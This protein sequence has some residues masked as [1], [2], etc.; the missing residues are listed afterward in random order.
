MLKLFS[1]FVDLKHLN[2][3]GGWAK[4]TRHVHLNYP[5][6][7]RAF[8]PRGKFHFYIHQY[9]KFLQCSIYMPANHD[10]CPLW[11]AH[12]V[13]QTVRKKNQQVTAMILLWLF[14]QA[15]CRV[16]RSASHELHGNNLSYNNS[17]ISLTNTGG[18][19]DLELI[20]WPLCQR[21]FGACMNC[22]QNNDPFAN[23]FFLW[24]VAC[25]IKAW[26]E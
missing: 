19:S 17:K 11:A 8:F 6:M 25:L 24:P 3:R 21:N 7:A 18:S 22:N 9:I 15:E 26:V 1:E 2:S 12:T 20:Q 14:H 4:S 5:L 16:H 23:V 10:L 13:T